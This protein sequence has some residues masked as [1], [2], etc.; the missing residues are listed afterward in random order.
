MGVRRRAR[1]G[2]LQLLYQLE[3]HVEPDREGL[4]AGVKVARPTVIEAPADLAQ[5][6]ETFFENF[7][8]PDKAR[9]YTEVLV[10]GVVADAAG[11]DELI[12][13]ESPKWQL[14]RMT[15]VDRN[16][17]RLATFELQGR[18]DIPGKVI[19]DEA[20]EIARRFGTEDSARFVNG[21]LDGLLSRLRNKT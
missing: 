21:V 7:S 19:L 11:I 3:A 6:F 9:E 12:Q 20:I 18:K 17:L 16:V 8:A 15:A 14:Q 13:N 4:P 2:A 5:L 10:N 1:E